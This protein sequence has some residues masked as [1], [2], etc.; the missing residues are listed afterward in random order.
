MATIH[1]GLV[2]DHNHG[3]GEH[4]GWLCNGCNS[5]LGFS[6]DNPEFLRALAGYL[7]THGYHPARELLQPLLSRPAPL[8][9]NNDFDAGCQGV[10]E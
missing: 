9:H 8:F 7:D 2:Y 4:R 6:G 3:T 10:C 5:A 1:V